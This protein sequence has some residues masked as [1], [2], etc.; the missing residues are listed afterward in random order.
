MTSSDPLPQWQDYVDILS[1]AGVLVDKLADSADPLAR[2]EVYR[3]LFMIIAT[4]FQTTFVDRDLPDFVPSVTN[5]MN[6]VGTNPDF[7]YASAAI[8]GAGQYRLS[9]ERGDGLFLLFDFAAGG[10]GVT[11]QLGPSVGTMDIDTMTITDGKF[12]VLLS[13]ERPA[14]HVGDWFP[15]DPRARTAVVR[16]AAYDWGVGREARI[17]IER[18]DRPIA[19]K[20]MDAAG[21]AERLAMLAAY[22]LRYGSFAMSY[23]EGQRARGLVNT[24]EHDDWAGRGGVA[25]QHYYQGIFRLQPGEALILE[26]ELPERVRYWNIQLNDPL[27]NS[28]DWFNH[29]SSLNG[30]QATLDPDGKFRAVIALEDPG[31]PNWL[32]PGG[33]AEGSLMLRWT[34]AS[35]GPVPS[36]KLV[37][38]AE[39][40]ASLHADTAE[41]TPEARQASLR[42]RRRGA[43]LRRRW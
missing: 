15:L 21:I 14:G 43:Q 12:D 3:L 13:T 5:V 39:V 10:L 17:A 1:N 42:E 11:E 33:H 24:L 28:I 36:L 8:D 31:V 19:P 2:Q 27:W 20:R 6:S 25:G 35:S 22:P 32:D 30:G 38:L 37:P 4:G 7:I 40:R 41:V 29:Q 34:E 16:Q 23:G 26:T 9:G 18:L